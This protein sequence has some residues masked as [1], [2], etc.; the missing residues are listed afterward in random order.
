MKI[1]T[2][3]IDDISNIIIDVIRKGNKIMV[4]GN[5]GS[6]S[7]SSHFVAEMIGKFKYIRRALPFLAL[8]TDTS[9]LTSIGN[10]IGFEY[11]FSRQVEG[12]GARGDLL[13]VLSTSGQS[14]NCLEAIKSAQKKGIFYEELIRIGK[15]T[16]EIQENHLKMIHLICARV[17]EVFI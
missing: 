14:K 6:S 13:I 2:S 4:C 10:D 8:T 11:V 12:L 9:I 7:Q 15:D 3:Y 1:P 17:E 16:S 5:G